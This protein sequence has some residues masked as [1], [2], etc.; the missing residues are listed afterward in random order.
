MVYVDD[1][2]FLG[3]NDSKLQD[4]IKE[5]QDLGLNID[6]KGHPADY[7]GVNIKKLRDGSYEFT[8]RAL[9]DSIINDVGIKDA[10]VKPVS[11][12]VSLQ[13]H[14]FKDKP[15]FN[16]NFNYR[17]AVG[18]LNYLAQTRED[19]VAE[20]ILMVNPLYPIMSVAMLNYEWCLALRSVLGTSGVWPK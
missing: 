14:A 4:A 20:L 17:S 16:L 13:L 1:G 2:I 11:A 8:Q 9:I 19:V 5:I 10:K 15:P 7:I 18:K 6:N 3:N 12:K